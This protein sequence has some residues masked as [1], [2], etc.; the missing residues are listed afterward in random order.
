MGANCEERHLALQKEGHLELRFT[1]NSRSD[2]GPD[3]VRNQEAIAHHIDQPH[4]DL[5]E[6]WQHALVGVVAAGVFENPADQCNQ[7]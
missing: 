1:G 4:P 6:V 3:L 5:K 7:G 2:H